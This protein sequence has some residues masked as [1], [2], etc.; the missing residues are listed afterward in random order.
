MSEAFYNQKDQL[1][2]DVRE[3]IESAEQLA[4]I[5]SSDASDEAQAF[6]A[7]ITHKLKAAKARL[8]DAEEV[9]LYH[10]KTAVKATDV[11]IH[12]NPYK[13]IGIAA[14]VGFLLGL[15]VSRR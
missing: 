10:A 4:E 12:E 3:V 9:A 8:I 11:Y 13:S 14:A 7:R 6:K 5:A 2:D 15:L 1:L